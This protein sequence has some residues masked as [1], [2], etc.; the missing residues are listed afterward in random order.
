MTDLEFIKNFSKIRISTICRNLKIQSN[1]IYTG[2][3]KKENIQKV[4]NEIYK[5][6]AKLMVGE[7]NE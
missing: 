5:E 6:L 2:K 1:N 4:K 7:K 3:T